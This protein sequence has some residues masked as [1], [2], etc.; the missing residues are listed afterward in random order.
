MSQHKIGLVLEGGG[1]RGAFTSGVLDY[2][3]E[4]NLY[5]HPIYCVSAGACNGLNYVSR[6]KGRSIDIYLKY[7]Q[8]KRY[9]SVR[10]WIFHKSFFGSDFIFDQMPKHEMPFD[11]ATYYQS[12]MEFF[13]G[14]T[15][16]NTGECEFFPKDLVMQNTEIAKASCALPIMSKTFYINGQP[17]LDGG[18]GDSIPIKKA[19]EDGCDKVV[20]VLTQDRTYQKTPSSAIRLAQ[21]VYK[22]YPKFLR[23]FEERHLNYNRM[24]KEIE[25]LQKEGKVFAFYPPNPVEV[26]RTEKDP[27]KLKDLYEIGY[28]EAKEQYEKFCTFLTN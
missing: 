9:M 18:I 13:V 8:D 28:Q 19:F 7:C 11:Y 10:N 5:I 15:N 26:G 20:V 23:K 2:L 17:Y 22:N 25:A 12:D 16:L 21:H 3:M 1:M 4:Q 6:Q 24:R 14:A 27:A